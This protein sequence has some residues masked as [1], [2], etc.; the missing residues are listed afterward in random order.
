MLKISFEIYEKYPDIFEEDIRGE[1][2]DFDGLEVLL[3]PEKSQE[4][5]KHI[6]ELLA[7]HN[8]IKKIIVEKTFQQ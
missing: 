5:L 3:N 6:K 8:P 2:T 4:K 1:K 7:V